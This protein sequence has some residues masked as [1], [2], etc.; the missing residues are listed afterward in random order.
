MFPRDVTF[1]D[2]ERL[3]RIAAAAVETLQMDEDTFRAFYDRTARPVWVY[4]ARITGDR[5]VADDLLQ[6]S[7]YRFLRA[8]RRFE[9]E[10]HRRN[11]LYRIA[12]NLANDRHRSRRGIVDVPVPAEHEQSALVDGRNAAADAERRTDLGRAMARLKPRERELLW[13]AYAHGASHEEIAASLGLR[14]SSIKMLLFRA[15]RR[16]AGLLTAR[17]PVRGSGV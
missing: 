16:L 2:V 10:S 7:Y 13:L 15:R 4:L 17:P 11:Y 3:D 12:T 5:G 8:G 6:E 14:R 9:S 1:L